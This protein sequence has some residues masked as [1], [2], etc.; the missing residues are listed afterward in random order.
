MKRR[1]FKKNKR[2]AHFMFERRAQ[3][4]GVEVPDAHLTVRRS[5][6]DHACAGRLGVRGRAV[7]GTDD[8]DEDDVFHALALGVPA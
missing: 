1:E 7:D 3:S 8:V 6:D 4:A 5:G 2:V